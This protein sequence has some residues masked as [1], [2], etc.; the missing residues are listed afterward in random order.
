MLHIGQKASVVDMTLRV[1]VAVADGNWVKKSVIGHVCIIHEIGFS[2]QT[3]MSY[4]RIIDIPKFLVYT[5]RNQVVPEL[6]TILYTLNAVM[7]FH[8]HPG[9]LHG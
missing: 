5:I 3:G 8:H 4:L 6:L 7:F 9:L 2:P 1:K